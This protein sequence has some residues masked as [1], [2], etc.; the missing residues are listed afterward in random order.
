MNS[1]NMSLLPLEKRCKARFPGSMHAMAIAQLGDHLGAWSN[2]FHTIKTGEIAFDKIEG[3]SIWEYYETHPEQGINFMKAMTGMTE[4][5]NR[6]IV[7]VSDFTQFKTIIDVGGGN[8]ALLFNIL[9]HA[10][11]AKGIIFEL[12]YVA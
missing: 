5:A 12:P 9:N 6:N 10:P 2:L 4:G 8:G 3:M 1:S 7:P 11:D